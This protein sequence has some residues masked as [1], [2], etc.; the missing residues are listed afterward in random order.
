MDE[1][2]VSG[3]AATRWKPVVEQWRAS[4]LTIRSFGLRN[5]LNEGT[6]F[7]WKRVFG[8]LP[9]SLSEFAGKDG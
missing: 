1:N 6:F 4:G 7:R 3:N 8:V 5:R 9:V 2:G